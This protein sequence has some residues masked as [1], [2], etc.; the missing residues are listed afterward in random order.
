MQSLR[1]IVNAPRRRLS[2]ILVANFLMPLSI[3]GIST[4]ATADNVYPTRPVRVIV[5]YG[6]GGTGDVIARI[7]GKKLE[8]SLRQPIV[9]ENRPGGIGM[10]GANSVA[11]SEGDGYT[12]LLGYT[13]EM[14]ISPHLIKQST[15]QT[16]RDFQPIAFAGATPLLLVAHPSVPA[17]NFKELVEL[18]KK[19]PK[20]YSYASAGNGSPAHIAGALFSKLVGADIMHVPYKGGS[21]AVA[22]VVAG[23]A[24]LYFSGIPPTVSFV[25]SKK[26]IPLGVTSSK[27]AAALPD[28]PPLTTQFPELD[29]SGWFGFFAPK[30]T[31]QPIVARL[32]KEI[33]ETLQMPDVKEQ[34]LQQGVEV[35]PMSVG[36]FTT[37]VKGEQTKYQRLIKELNITQ[38]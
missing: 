23:H 9:I 1:R 3:F 15:Y 27:P 6:P 38:E 25:K 14:T 7:V 11:K 36:Q 5:P 24:S 13:S 32:N 16:E 12:I 20:A 37:F 2:A 31:P 26:L 30:N 18:V 19:N 21:Q 28:V 22:D 34:L 17:K 8:T 10:I 29:L 33:T 35:N 4:D